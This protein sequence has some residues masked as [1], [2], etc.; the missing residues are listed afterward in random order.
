MVTLAEHAVIPQMSAH[1]FPA[2]ME[3]L[4]KICILTTIVHVWL[5]TLERIVKPILTTVLRRPC[6]ITVSVKMASITLLVTAMLDLPEGCVMTILM[7]VEVISV[8][9]EH[10]VL[11]ELLS[12]HAHVL[13]VLRDHYAAITL[14]IAYQQ[15]A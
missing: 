14:T 8:P 12:T 3:R 13:R 10:H 1:C 11:M 6:V 4:V 2:K 7:T 5:A 15:C 9:M